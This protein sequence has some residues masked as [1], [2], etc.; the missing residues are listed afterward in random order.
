[1]RAGELGEV[2]RVNYY[3]AQRPAS[4]RAAMAGGTTPAAGRAGPAARPQGAAASWSPSS[5]PGA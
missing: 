2:L 4:E 1:M 3:R 5:Q